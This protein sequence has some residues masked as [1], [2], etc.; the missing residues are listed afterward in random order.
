MERTEESISELEHRI[1]I[2]QPEKQGENKLK[3]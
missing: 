1:A 2:I 3:K